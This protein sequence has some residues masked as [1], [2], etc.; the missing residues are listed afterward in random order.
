[1][2][3]DLQVDLHI[4]HALHF[5]EVARRMLAADI[6]VKSYQT[7]HLAGEDRVPGTS[8]PRVHRLLRGC[9]A[10]LGAR[11]AGSSSDGETA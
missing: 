8:D 10:A 7:D 4:L 9:A 5:R 1:M 6:V 2:L 11:A 3:L